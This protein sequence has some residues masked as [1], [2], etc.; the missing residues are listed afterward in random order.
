MTHKTKAPFCHWAIEE[1]ARAAGPGL[2]PAGR[3][4]FDRSLYPRYENRKAPPPR[5]RPSHVRGTSEARPRHVRGTSE[6]RPRHVRALLPRLREPHG[7]PLPAR[8][9]ASGGRAGVRIRA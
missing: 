8:A 5:A 6:A 1:Q 4:V 7:P 9:C 3:V 2:E